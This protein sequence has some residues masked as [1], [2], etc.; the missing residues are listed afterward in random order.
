MSKLMLPA[1][2]YV[3]LNLWHKK[4]F[5]VPREE[6]QDTYLKEPLIHFVVCSLSHSLSLA[7]CVYVYMIMLRS[8]YEY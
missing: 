1:L 5:C 6:K 2:P 4:Y 8:S 7:L 3:H